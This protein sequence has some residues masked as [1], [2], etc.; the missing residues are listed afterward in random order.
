MFQSIIHINALRLL[1]LLTTIFVIVAF[2]SINAETRNT[3]VNKSITKSQTLVQKFYSKTHQKIYWFSSAVKIK[4]A[5]DWL[6]LIERGN[7]VGIVP[8]ILL[9][10]EL[11]MD[12]D[13]Y[14]LPIDSVSVL[15]SDWLI[16]AMV[17]NY[18]KTLQE[19]NIHFRYDEINVSRD[20]DYVK[21]L[22][23]IKRNISKSAS[24]FD[25][26]DRDYLILKNYL[27]DSLTSTDTL[28]QKSV[29]TAMNYCRYLSLNRQK[30]YILINIPEMEANYYR[31][32]ILKINMRIVVGKKLKQTPII[33]S[34]MTSI[35]TFPN[36]SVPES[37]AEE[38]ILPK[39]LKDSVYLK[40]NNIIVL[41]NRGDTIDYAD[42]NWKEYKKNDFPYNFS[43]SSGAENAMGVLKFNFKNPFS[44]YLHGTSFQGVFD[45]A[46]R[47]RSHGCIRLEKPLELAKAILRGKIDL[48]ELRNG[49]SNTKSKIIKTPHKIPVFIIY[50]PLKVMNGKLSFLADTY[51]LMK[52]NEY[53]EK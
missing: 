27:R 20:S 16:S 19:G 8:N 38:E 43:Q 34:Y 4:N 1:R 10:N 32:D 14:I 7:N 26:S 6:D 29:M 49:K 52:W 41:N 28:K 53:E 51:G 2:V 45:E 12:L 39:A 44:I 36:W 33:A 40:R 24:K 3:V 23:S 13:E 42:L 30:E 35:T 37:I 11:R 47:F 25:C 31:N 15:K 17:L 48:V 21:Q 18:I 46:Y 50:V 5:K 22:L 9:I